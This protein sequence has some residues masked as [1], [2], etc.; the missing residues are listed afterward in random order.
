MLEICP[1]ITRG[2]QG[3]L[4]LHDG[5]AVFII[6]VFLIL[7]K[8]AIFH[9]KRIL[10]TNLPYWWH[11]LKPHSRHGGLFYTSWTVGFWDKLWTLSIMLSSKI[12]NGDTFAGPLPHYHVADGTDGQKRGQGGCVSPGCG[13]LSQEGKGEL[14]LGCGWVC[15][16]LLL[17]N[18]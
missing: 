9:N 1:K 4:W 14:V 16:W 12:G 3:S 10:C 15:S 2:R 7:Y 13:G 11:T 8:L 6:L 17:I 5:D 18:P